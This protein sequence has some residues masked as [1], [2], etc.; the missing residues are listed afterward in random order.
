MIIERFEELGLNLVNRVMILSHTDN[1]DVIGVYSNIKDCTRAMRFCS[2]FEG[3]KFLVHVMSIDTSP[4]GS[5]DG[6]YTVTTNKV[7]EQ[8]MW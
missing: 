6:L 3:K 2:S 7:D 4:E 8:E 1:Y 5:T